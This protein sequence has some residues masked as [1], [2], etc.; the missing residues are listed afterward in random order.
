MFDDEAKL[1][2]FLFYHKESIYT[3]GETPLVLWLFPFMIEEVLTMFRV[4]P[5]YNSQK[6][7]GYKNYLDY[8][9]EFNKRQEKKNKRRGKKEKK[10]EADESRGDNLTEVVEVDEMQKMIDLEKHGGDV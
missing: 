2:G 6:P 9:E 1:D 3:S 4:N 8:I 5:I 7:L 10:M